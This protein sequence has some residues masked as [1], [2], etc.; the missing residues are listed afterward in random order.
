MQIANR[1]D[2][3]ADLVFLENAFATKAH[4]ALLAS[5]HVVCFFWFPKIFRSHDFLSALHRFLQ[6]LCCHMR[7]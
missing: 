1:S 5:S 3:E 2:A 7:R 6:A 4:T